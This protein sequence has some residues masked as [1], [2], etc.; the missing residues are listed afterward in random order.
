MKQL[1]RLTTLAF[2]LF[3]PL[4]AHAAGAN[5]FEK[6]LMHPM[7]VPIHLIAVFALGLLLGQQGWRV[8]RI[9]LPAFLVAI[10][11]ALVLTRYHS[12][13]WDPELILL[14]TA[15]ITGLLLTLKKQWFIIIPLV[16]AIVIAAVIGFD[17]S[18]P[19][20]PG[21]QV[22]KIYA[23]LAGTGIAIFGLLLIVTLIAYALR[24]L[25]HGIV[26]RILGA[27]S[28]AGAVLVLALLLANAART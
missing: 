13:S 12:A 22:R 26:L 6:G 9:V 1:A 21:L 7:T 3:S 4:A 5:F 25:I 2:F 24:N 27:W 15:A 28:A 19:M 20:I 10:G 8:I 14:P 23:S 18:V 11:A 17:S 16:L